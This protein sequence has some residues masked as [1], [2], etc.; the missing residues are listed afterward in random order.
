MINLVNPNAYVPAVPI[1]PVP[2][3]FLLCNEA[4]GTNLLHQDAVTA[5]SML[6]QGAMP[7]TYSVEEPE[8]EGHAANVSTLGS[9]YSLPFL[10]IFDSIAISV[11]VSGPLDIKE[12]NVVPNDI[13]GMAAFVANECLGRGRVGGFV[14]KKIQGLVDFVTDPTSDIDNVPYPDSAAFL[15]L[16]VT[17]P[18]TSAAFPGDFDP[19]MAGLLWKSELDALERVEDYYRPVIAE[20]LDR[21]LKAQHQMRRLGVQ[22]AWWE[23][24]VAQGNRTA[25]A[26]LHLTNTTA[27]SGATARRRRRLTGL[28]R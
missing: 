16:A 12:I 13:R 5:A 18:E 7:V 28:S 20:R 26:S 6:P 14:T 10:E 11:D 17:S 8:L 27:E 1:P 2:P 4:Y 24:E 23:R 25:S 9:G 15:T 22:L 3:N 19:Q 21:F